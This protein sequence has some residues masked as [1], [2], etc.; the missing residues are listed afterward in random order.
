MR[1]VT[2]HTWVNGDDR[3]GLA[4]IAVIVVAAEGLVVSIHGVCRVRPQRVWLEAPPVL[5]Y[6]PT[7]HPAA[8]VVQIRLQLLV[9]G[10]GLRHA[11]LPTR[12]AGG[13]CRRRRRGWARRLRKRKKKHNP[14]QSMVKIGRIWN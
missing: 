10:G 9:T 4:E 6:S 12:P 5:L 7:V 11:P 13:R 8:R 14:D 3:P 2:L 1:E